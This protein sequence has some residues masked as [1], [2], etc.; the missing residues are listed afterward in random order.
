MTGMKWLGIM[1]H[2][3]CAQGHHLEWDF[4]VTACKALKWRT[5]QQG[6]M[7]GLTAYKWEKTHRKQILSRKWGN[8]IGGRFPPHW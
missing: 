7:P 8:S 5:Q 6:Q 3:L 4:P 2:E 1:E